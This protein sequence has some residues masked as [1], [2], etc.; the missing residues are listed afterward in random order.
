M[1]HAIIRKDREFYPRMSFFDDFF[2]RFFD[3][4]FIEDTQR[5]MAVDIIEHDDKY[6]IQANLPGFQKKDIKIS[7]NNNELVIEAN[8]EE[9]KEEK[10]GSYCRCERY[11]GSYRRV[12]TL[13]DQTDKEK[14]NAKFED[15]VLTLDILKI[16]PQPVKEIKIG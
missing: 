1:R 14:I 15:G 3:N 6:E 7:I 2:N 16:E 5:I 10:K 9:T 11:K 8:K 13:S 4:E 12:L